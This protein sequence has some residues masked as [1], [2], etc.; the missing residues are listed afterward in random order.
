VN[1]WTHFKTELDF[2][3]AE[4]IENMVT[5]DGIEPDP[6]SHDFRFVD[7]LETQISSGRPREFC[8]RDRVFDLWS[9][10]PPCPKVRFGF[11][12]LRHALSSFLVKNGTDLKTV[13][14]MLRHSDGNSQSRCTVSEIGN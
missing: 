5:R 11:H 7:A 1:F 14:Q 10:V 4:V 6:D 3:S 2:T 13:R 8:D 9:T 12:T